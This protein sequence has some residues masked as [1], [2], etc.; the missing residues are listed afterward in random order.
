MG[1]V[2]RQMLLVK[3]F[4]LAARFASQRPAYQTSARL[5]VQIMEVTRPNSL[6][7]SHLLLID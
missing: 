4:V 7:E 2:S 6:W 3:G 5:I 1:C